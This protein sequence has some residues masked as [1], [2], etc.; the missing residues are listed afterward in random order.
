VTQL[1]NRPK[2]SAAW[3][4]F[5][6][7]QAAG[8]RCLEGATPETTQVFARH[9]SAFGASLAPQTDVLD[10]GCGGG[11]VARWLMNGRGDLRVTGIDIA[12]VPDSRDAR[13]ELLSYTPME[14]LPFAD[15]SFGAAVS[16]FGFEY[17]QTDRASRELARVL[18]P[19]APFSFL[20][21]HAAGSIVASSRDR[22]RALSV[23]LGREMAGA[24]VSGDGRSLNAQISFLKD[25]YPHEHLITELAMHLPA[26]MNQ[27]RDERIRMWKDLETALA[28]EC[29][30]LEAMSECCVGADEIEDWLLPFRNLF[31]VSNT[32]IARK[33]GGQPIVWRID[34][35]R[36]SAAC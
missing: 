28:P 1:Y 12:E 18:A 26:R 6:R 19:H 31:A 17:G 11:A 34:G 16:Q 7:E 21:H 36:N 32:A 9:W 10:I 3:S 33:N 2:T 15:A 25:A 22:L 24:F 8:S 30:I 20:I 35:I 23:F 4:I 29:R 14:A 5:W 27:G 13:V